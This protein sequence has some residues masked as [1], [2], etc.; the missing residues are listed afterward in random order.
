MAWY[1]KYLTAFERPY[2]EV[3]AEV[4]EMVREKLKKFRPEETPLCTAV[5]I[6]HNEEKHMLACLWALADSIVDFPVEIIVVDNDSTDSTPQILD[7]LG[8]TWYE[9]RKY[10][11]CGSGRQC[12]LEHTRGRFTI[13]VDSDTLYPPHYIATHV[14]HL[15]QEGVACSYSLWSYVPDRN[16]SKF[17]LFFYDILRAVY[18]SLININRPEFAARGMTLAFRTDL[19]RQVG[20]F[21]INV[22]R[23]EDGAMVSELKHLGKTKLI[24]SRKAIPVTSYGTLDASGSSLWGNMWRRVWHYLRRWRNFFTSQAHYEDLDYNLCKKEEGNKE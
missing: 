22:R 10:H 23:G 18:V 17:G 7:E 19:A 1:E 13:D 21:R 8:V 5:V 3:P 11:C 12:G 9:D 24:L 16:H 15:Q 4:K 2:K 14:R 6:G 20:G